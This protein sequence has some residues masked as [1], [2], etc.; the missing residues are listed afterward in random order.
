MGL[1]FSLTSY[2]L[3][4]SGF[5]ESQVEAAVAEVGFEEALG[6]IEADVE[7]FAE[8]RGVETAIR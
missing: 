1:D 7:V 2:L 6:G 5:G 8:G 4:R 3:Y